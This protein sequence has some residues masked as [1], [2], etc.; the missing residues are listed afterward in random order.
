MADAMVAGE[1][2]PPGPQPPYMVSKQWS[3]LPP[4]IIDSAPFGAPVTSTHCTTGRLPMTI[5]KDELNVASQTLASPFVLHRLCIR[6]SIKSRLLQ[7]FRIGHAKAMPSSH[8][9]LVH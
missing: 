9:E 5:V 8:L 7:T 1:Q 2:T 3:L 4:V 6:A